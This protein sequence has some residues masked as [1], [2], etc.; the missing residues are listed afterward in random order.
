MLENSN[1]IFML[2]FERGSPKHIYW[3]L[4]RPFIGNGGFS[5]EGGVKVS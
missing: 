1:S 2:N 4:N 3:H 5:A